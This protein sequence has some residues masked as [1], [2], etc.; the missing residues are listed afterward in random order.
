[1]SYILASEL[2]AFQRHIHIKRKYYIQKK[3]THKVQNYLQ[4]RKLQSGP[5]LDLDIFMGVT[6]FK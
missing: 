5:Q 6:F 2:Y 4:S 3:H 1:M